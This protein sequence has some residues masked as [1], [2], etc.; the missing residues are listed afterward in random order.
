MIELMGCGGRTRSEMIV[1]QADLIK[2][3]QS[4]LRGV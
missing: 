2:F 3:A 1:P 4:I